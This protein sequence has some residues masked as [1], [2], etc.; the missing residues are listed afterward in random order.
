MKSQ[1]FDFFPLQIELISMAGNESCTYQWC[2]MKGKGEKEKREKREEKESQKSFFVFSQLHIDGSKCVL[3]K[4]QWSKNVSLVNMWAWMK[5]L[6][7]SQ[8]SSKTS[9]SVGE[10]ESLLSKFSNWSITRVPT[11]LFV[12]FL[13]MADLADHHFVKIQHHHCNYF[14]LYFQVCL[15]SLGYY[16]YTLDLDYGL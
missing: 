16:K 10:P 2:G 7:I 13:I 9:L 14:W 5:L 8:R 11:C 1:N 12:W 3:M 15:W 6:H 4:D